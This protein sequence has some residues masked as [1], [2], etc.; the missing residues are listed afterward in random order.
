MTRARLNL[1]PSL[2]QSDDPY[3][4]RFERVDCLGQIRLGDKHVLAR[5]RRCVDHG[6]GDLHGAGG[7]ND[8]AMHAKRLGGAD[9]RA[10]VLRVLQGIKHENKRHFTFGMFED[11]DHIRVGI[12]AHFGDDALIILVDFIQLG[13]RHAVDPY[14]LHLCQFEDLV[15]LAFVLHALG[16]VDGKYL[17]A[18]RAQGFIH[19]IA[20]IDEFFHMGLILLYS[21]HPERRDTCKERLLLYA[22]QKN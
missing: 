8:H 17:P 14:L 4:I 5:A 9:E 15:D 21:C 7:G 11:L 18:F 6:G 13:A 10:E 3:I 12:A 22:C 16:D 20:G 1:R 2:I 19:C